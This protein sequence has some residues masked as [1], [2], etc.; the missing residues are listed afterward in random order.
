MDNKPSTHYQPPFVTKFNRSTRLWNLFGQKKIDLSEESLIA[1]ARAETGLERFGD[2]SFLAPLRML[3]QSLETEADLN[4]FGRFNARMRTIRSLKNRLWANACFEA[5]PE[6]LAQNIET[7]IVIVGPHRSGTTRLQRMMATDTRLQH[8]KT[9][10]GF[11]PAPRPG[12]P[13]MGKQARREEVRQFLDM[14]KQIYTGGHIA[15]PM[16][17]DW[18]EEDM[19]LLNHSFCGFSVLGM[20]HVPSYY[21][22]FLDYDKTEVYRY[23]A[24]LM[25]LISWSRGD[26]ADKRWVLKNP[27]HMLDLDTLLKVF[28]DARLV[29]THRDPLKTVGSVMSLMWYF[30]VQH[31]DVPC[32]ARTRDVWMDFCEQAAR[33]A[34]DA[35]EQIPAAQQMDVHYDDMNRDW[36][37]AMHRIYAFAG[38]EFTPQGE[39]EMQ[40]WLSASESENLHGGHRYALEDFG[41]SAD[42]VDRRMMFVRERYAI[43]YE[44]K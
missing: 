6:I 25:K 31:T 18:P 41:T 7:P 4:P 9:W 15:H 30:A 20:F 24:K 16:D 43:A 44:G 3:L 5:H 36:R 10:E 29:F 37:A 33:R 40:A 21:R 28:P 27:Q 42:E 1:A 8:L 22:W 11:N 13:E 39:Q 38:M 35:R 14:G 23:T 19:L 2:E 34:I 12:Q 26:G 32:R 17:A